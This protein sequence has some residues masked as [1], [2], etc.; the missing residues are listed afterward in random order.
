MAVV[1]HAS[2]VYWNTSC[3]VLVRDALIRTELKAL[4]SECKMGAVTYVEDLDQALL[5]LCGEAKTQMVIC[6]A[7]AHAEDHLALT[8]F[9]R[10][11]EFSKDISIPVV[12]LSAVWTQKSFDAARQSGA[13]AL[14]VMPMPFHAL[15]RRFMSIQLS[16]RAFITSDYYRGVDRRLQSN[17][18]FPGPYRRSRDRDALKDPTYVEPAKHRP[19]PPKPP[20]A[21]QTDPSVGKQAELM[22]TLKKQPPDP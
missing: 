15:F 1:R 13:T 14:M 9:V 17:P 8:S 12:I 20:L 7:I 21:A 16:D 4:L 5:H 11:S 2:S 6:D 19:V 18:A 22:Q 3:L 10:W